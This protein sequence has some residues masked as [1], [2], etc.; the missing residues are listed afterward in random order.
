MQAREN[1]SLE[2]LDLMSGQNITGSYISKHHYFSH[3]FTCYRKFID[4]LFNNGDVNTNKIATMLN[5]LGGEDNKNQNKI[6]NFIYILGEIVA[7]IEIYTEK[8]T[9]GHKIE[10]YEKLF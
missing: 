5:L 4:T 2:F 6:T 10:D 1:E 8:N 3:I 9:T 7:Y